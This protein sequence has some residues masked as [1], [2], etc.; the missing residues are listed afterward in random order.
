[1]IRAVVGGA[2]DADGRAGVA[3][4]GSSVPLHVEAELTIAADATLHYVDDLVR[5]LAARGERPTSRQTGALIAAAYRAW[6]LDAAAQLEGDFA[7]VLWDAGRRRVVAARDF[8]GRRPLHHALVGPRLGLASEPAALLTVPGASTA[9]HIE[10]LAGRAAGLLEAWESAYA[11]IRVLAAGRTLTA[12][13]GRDGAV[14]SV[15]VTRHWE[16]PTFEQDDG[17]S[18]DDAAEELRACLL[19][20]VRERLDPDAP[21][22]VWLSGGYDSPAV[23]GAARAAATYRDAVRAVSMSYPPG[24]PGREDE[25][26]TAAAAR[27]NAPVTWRDV[28]DVPVLGDALAWAGRRPQPFAHAFEHWLRTLADAAHGEGARVVLDGSGGDQLFQVSPV[29]LADLVRRGRWLAA[30]REWHAQGLAGAGWRRLARAAVLPQLPPWGWTLAGRLRGGRALRGLRAGVIPPWIRRHGALWDALAARAELRLRPRP[31]E[32]A[33][34]LESRWYLETSYSAAVFAEQSRIAREAGVE[35]RSPLYDGRLVRLAATRPRWERAGGGE[36]KRLLRQAAA[37]WLPAELVAKRLS[38]TGVTSAYFTR[39][40]VRELPGLVPR[41]IN[42]PVLAELGVLEPGS[43]RQGVE[44]YCRAPD[45][46]LGAALFAT[47][48]TELWLR[49]RAS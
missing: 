32:S 43:F 47:L 2:S 33:A 46:E 21:T 18:L 38:R 14:A 13:V 41:V 1:M 39:L 26:I 12:E 31:G 7:F 23:F 17:R 24:D 9:L 48:Q 8:M 16:P 42:T 37:G 4:A 5:R 3:W 36:S 40:M 49:A 45:A 28:D 35:V 44:R 15:A 25:L 6:G 20:A 30:R 22:A 11:G 34:A 29:Y 10:H 19:D 27:W